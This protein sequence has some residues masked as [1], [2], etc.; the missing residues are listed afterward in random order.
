MAGQVP[1]GIARIAR[2]AEFQVTLDGQPVDRA[3]ILY[4]GAA[5]G[6]AGLYQIN[7]KLPSN[8][9]HNPGGPNRVCRCDEPDGIA[10]ARRPTQPI[11]LRERLHWSKGLILYAISRSAP[12]VFPPAR[13]VR[14]AEAKTEAPAANATVEAHETATKQ[15]VIKPGTRIP[16]SLINSVSTKSAAEGDRV[17][18]ETVFPIVL[19]GRIVIAPGSY[20]AGT[21]TQVKRPGR[22]KGRG[23]TVPPFRLA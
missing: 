10:V 8:L 23:R 2:V 3:N 5:P 11:A 4:V 18:L 16:L 21:V 13:I 20:V 12:C 19:D 1:T 17:Y 9:P 22:V 7:L 14:S 15:Y 6:F